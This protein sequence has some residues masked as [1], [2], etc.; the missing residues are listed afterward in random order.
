MFTIIDTL[1]F[2][3]PTAVYIVRPTTLLQVQQ[4]PVA[5]STEAV[6]DK[7]VNA[8]LITGVTVIKKF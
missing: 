6:P 3:M 4:T 2:I 8:R 7:T 1:Q 5:A